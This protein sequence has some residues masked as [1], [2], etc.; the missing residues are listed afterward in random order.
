VLYLLLALLRLLGL[1]LC[2]PRPL[3]RTL[4]VVACVGT[5]AHDD[6]ANL[7]AARR[8]RSHPLSVRHVLIPYEWSLTNQ[9]FSHY[10]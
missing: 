5:F 9:D 7:L 6:L 2:V 4:S 1:L 3:R 10:P 8:L